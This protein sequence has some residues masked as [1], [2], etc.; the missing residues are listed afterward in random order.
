MGTY[1]P[2]NILQCNVVC[3]VMNIYPDTC[4]VHSSCNIF[5][6]CRSCSMNFSEYLS[7]AEWYRNLSAFRRQCFE[8]LFFDFPQPV[9]VS[10]CPKWENRISPIHKS[11]ICTTKSSLIKRISKCLSLSLAKHN[12]FIVCQ[13]YIFVI[14]GVN[15]IKINQI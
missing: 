9:V 13:K 15:L 3:A 7:F 1:N 11:F 8:C 10:L 6:T 2:E 5:L 12:C 4:D 14:K